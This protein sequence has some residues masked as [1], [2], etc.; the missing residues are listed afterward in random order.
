[1]SKKLWEASKK[2]KN[3]SNLLKYEKFLS[4]KFKYKVSKKYKKLFRWSIQNK[5]K[6]W[7]SI[8]DFC[9][10][11]GEKKEKYLISSSFFNNKFLV[12][13]KVNFAENILSKKDNSKAITFIS[14][15][16]FKEKVSWKELNE[17]TSKVIKFF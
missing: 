5:D 10:V 14:E 1:M 15:N 3:N 9:N 13:S 6:F 7:S 12:N 11:K 8:W 17:N 2:E 16:G 4:K